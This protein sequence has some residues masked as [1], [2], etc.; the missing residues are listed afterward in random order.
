MLALF[1]CFYPCEISSSHGGEYEAQNLLGCTAVFLTECRP[2]FQR[3]VL[4]P[5]SGRWVSSAFI[6]LKFLLIFGFIFTF[7]LPYKFIVFIYLFILFFPPAL[8]WILVNLFLVSFLSALFPC[9]Y[10]TFFKSI[11]QAWDNKDF[12]LSCF[13]HSLSPSHWAHHVTWTT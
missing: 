2:P 13:A 4:P 9:A 12:K 6:S 1:V 11:F 7:L 10:F 8:R 5:S 3:C